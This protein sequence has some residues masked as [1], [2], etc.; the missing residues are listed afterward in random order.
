ME[1]VIEG[2]ESHVNVLKCSKVIFPETVLVNLR[3]IH[4]SVVHP[5]GGEEF[6]FFIL[7][8]QEVVEGHISSLGVLSNDGQVVEKG[9]E[10]LTFNSNLWGNK[11]GSCWVRE[12]WLGP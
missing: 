12:P 11:C 10:M 9:L 5:F 1:I 2:S 7:I 6:S 4:S 8:H 3:I